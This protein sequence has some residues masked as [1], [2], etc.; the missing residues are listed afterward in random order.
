M[1]EKKVIITGEDEE[2][3]PIATIYHPVHPEGLAGL[4]LQT[5]ARDGR[6]ELAE[7]RR[8][9][10]AIE[11]RRGEAPS[12]EPPAP[13]APPS[14]S[15]PV[16][17]ARPVPV[18]AIRTDGGT[19]VRVQLSLTTVEEYA[20]AIRAGGTLPPV[21]AYHDGDAY[22]LAD[23]FHRL[24]GAT[25]AGHTEILAE[26][27]PG[28]RRDA[29]LHAVG[30]NAEHGL[31]RSNADK[32]RAV[33]LLLSDPDWAKWSD[34]KIAQACRVSHHLVG[35]MR[36][37]LTSRTRSEHQGERRYTT[38]HGTPASMNTAN[39]GHRPPAQDPRPQEPEEERSPES[40]PPAEAPP[41]P[42]PRSLAAL[43]GQVVEELRALAMRVRADG[44]G[45]ED[46]IAAMTQIIL[47]AL[48][49]AGREH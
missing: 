31:R 18:R 35:E 49:A 38:K 28:T 19:Q 22:W 45:H 29:L 13:A 21:I 40:T 6:D 24:M 17:E 20:E 4:A 41:P 33:E 7:L 8:E 15:H 12:A 1:D 5:A 46:T 48:Q 25:A 44:L 23:G 43:A 36:A 30:C 9:G 27:R 11:D 2:G 26:V 37:T 34:N 10:Y 14:P 47:R 16:T 3:R 42:A 32:R 39:I